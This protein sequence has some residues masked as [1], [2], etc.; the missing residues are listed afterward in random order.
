MCA[1]AGPLAD[2]ES[3]VCLKDLFNHLGLDELYTE[4]GFP[5]VGPSTDLRSSY[6]LNTGI[7][8]IEVV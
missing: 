1:V 6:I 4:A 2:V 3:M 5:T 7:A 8:G